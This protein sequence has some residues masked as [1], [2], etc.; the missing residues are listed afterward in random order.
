MFKRE[1]LVPFISKANTTTTTLQANETFTGISQYVLGYIN[2]NL[3]ISFGKLSTFF[4]CKFK[5][6]IYFDLSL[7]NL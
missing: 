2:I 4:K 1:N 7:I 6:D 5:I 3:I